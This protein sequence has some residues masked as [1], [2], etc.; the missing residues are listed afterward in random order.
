MTAL[1]LAALSALAWVASAPA[2]TGQPA[3]HPPVGA[4][5]AEYT[6]TI[7]AFRPEYELPAPGSYTLPPID[8]VGDHALLASDGSAVQLAALTRGR[9]AVIA[10]VYTTCSEATGCPLADAILQRV[11]RQLAADPSLAARVRLLTISFDPERD[12][13]QRMAM[14]RTAFAP[15]TDWAFLTARDEAQLAPV[16]DDFGQAVAKLRYED[17]TWTG[18][19][20]HVLKMY[21]VDEQHRVR[22]IYSTGLMSP[23]L[24]L[25]DL[26]T[27][28][29]K[30]R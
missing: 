24:V 10:F 11:D 21:L 2:P 27:L 20:R 1:A 12:T 25:N 26:R 9:L 19:Y 14:I 29:G 4:S 18:L 7:G 8:R 23:E 15:K 30:T 6:Y 28:A 16:L 13:P 3:E 22:N 5:D 17:G